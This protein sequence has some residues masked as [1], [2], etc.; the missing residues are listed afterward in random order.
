MDGDDMEIVSGAI[1]AGGHV[2]RS[3]GR[4][5]CHQQ[6]L[7]KGLGARPLLDDFA[8]AKDPQ[9][10]P[11]SDASLIRSAQC[12]TPPFD[13]AIH[14]WRDLPHLRAHG[15]LFELAAHVPRG[16]GGVE[17]RRVLVAQAE[18]DGVP[19]GERA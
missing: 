7:R 16:R 2:E 3:F 4:D 6:A 10:L 18:G 11:A 12:V 13:A 1:V 19:V 9:R 14:T 15:V 8:S 5:H 17:E